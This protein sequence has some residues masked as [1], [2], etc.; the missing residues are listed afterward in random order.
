MKTVFSSNSQLCHVWANQSQDRGKANNMFFEDNVVYSYGYHYPAGV[1]HNTKYGAFALINS[2]FYSPTTSQHT[3]N[4]SRACYGLMETFH[5][6]NPHNPKGGAEALWEHVENHIEYCLKTNI[7]ID[8]TEYLRSK[9]ETLNR[10]IED[11]NALRVLIGL[12][13][14]QVPQKTRDKML[15]NLEA[16]LKRYRELNTPEMIAKREK[17]KAK[18]DARKAEK[19]ALA[20]KE[21]IERFR[22]GEWA[23]YLNLPYEILRIQENTVKT[24]AGAEVPLDIARR[25]L[26]LIENGQHEKTIGKHIG[27]FTID[28]FIDIEGDTVIRIG[29]HSILL[30]EAR[31]V[32]FEQKEKTA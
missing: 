6:P 20:Q 10:Y 9:F 15:V 13:P 7:K 23:G 8:S 3:S 4:A 30:S 17:A 25:M 1:I 27:H 12:K 21:K 24:S 11:A 18:R 2:T 22:K 28:D 5:V 14:K 16:R 26:M 31:S 29:C 32:L 19:E